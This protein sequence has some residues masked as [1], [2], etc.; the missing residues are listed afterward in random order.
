[1]TSLTDPSPGERRRQAERLANAVALCDRRASADEL[2]AAAS[3]CSTPPELAQA[4]Q[5]PLPLRFP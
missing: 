2:A 3:V 1:M 4:P 5:R